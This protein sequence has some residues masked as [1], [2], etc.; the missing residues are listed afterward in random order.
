MATQMAT[1]VSKEQIR[2]ARTADIVAYLQACGL[3]ENL[4][5]EGVN[6]RFQGHQ[7][8]LI[9]DHY[10][11]QHSTG[12]KGNAIDFCITFLGLSFTEAVQ[13]LTGKSV[14]TKHSHFFLRSVDTSLEMPEPAEDMRRVYAYLCK[15]RGIDTRVVQQAVEHGMYQDVKGNCVFPL[16]T[17]GKVT[18][19][20]VVGTLSDI[21]FKQQLGKGVFSIGAKLPETIMFFESA[22][23]ALS[24]ATL[25]NICHTTLPTLLVSLA[26]LK[27]SNIQHI[28]EMYANCELLYCF[29]SDT[30][31]RAAAERCISEHGGRLIIPPDE[32]DWNDVLLKKITE[33]RKKED[34]KGS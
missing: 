30:A 7:G 5:K 2:Q 21:R 34:E 9:R 20:E 17:K 27:T 1:Q 8:L 23:D 15:T 26:G 18:G 24:Y 14:S 29:D 10:W 22:I 31:G 12:Q 28:K 33:R 13:E 16:K 4:Q 32:K 25:I 3:G 19:C 6:Y 11:Y